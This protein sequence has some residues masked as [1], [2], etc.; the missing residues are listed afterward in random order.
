MSSEADVT[1]RDFLKTAAKTTAGARVF[2]GLNDFAGELQTGNVLRITWR[3]GI[4]TQTLQD[5]RAI[6]S[7]R[8]HAH[9]HSIRCRARRIGEVANLEAFNA[10]EGNNCDCFHDEAE[11]NSK[12]CVRD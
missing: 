6:Q 12:A 8:A 3:R 1:R 9:P 4:A 10:A 11:A 5:V 7:G 2:T